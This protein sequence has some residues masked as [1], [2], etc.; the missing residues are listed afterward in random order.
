M[1]CEE[2]WPVY[3]GEVSGKGNGKVNH[4]L[5]ISGGFLATV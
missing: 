4:T 2:H 1:S 3:Q 5:S